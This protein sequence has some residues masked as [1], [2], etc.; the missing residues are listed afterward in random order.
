MLRR[1]DW[2]SDFLSYTLEPLA[3]LWPLLRRKR[4]RCTFG[5]RVRMNLER[6]PTQI[7]LQFSR[8]LFG[9]N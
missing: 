7:S 1:V 5:R 2:K 3:N 8:R 4:L 6:K 9:P